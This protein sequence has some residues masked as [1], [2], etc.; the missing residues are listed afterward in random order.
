MFFVAV[1]VVGI[2]GTSFGQAFGETATPSY[3]QLEGRLDFSPGQ[4]GQAECK[5]DQALGCNL[6]FIG[7]EFSGTAI[8]RAFLSEDPS[9]EGVPPA[10]IDFDPDELGKLQLVQDPQGRYWVQQFYLKQREIE[11]LLSHTCE[12]PALGFG[13][14]TVGGG[15][16]VFTFDTQGLGQYYSQSAPV[17]EN[18]LGTYNSGQ[19]YTASLSFVQENYIPEGG[20]K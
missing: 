15:K 4:S 7:L 12:L 5:L 11:W 19:P 9:S 14:N 13:V 20:H 18:F 10:T 17:C 6:T 1:G 16:M 8:T 2:M 3:I